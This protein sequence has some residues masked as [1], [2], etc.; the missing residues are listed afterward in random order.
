MV[1]DTETNSFHP[2]V[3]DNAFYETDCTQSNISIF[4]AGNASKLLIYSFYLSF[5]LIT[6]YIY[7]RHKGLSQ[8]NQYINDLSKME[9]SKFSFAQLQ[10][11]KF[12]KDKMFDSFLKIWFLLS[13]FI[14]P[15]YLCVIWLFYVIRFNDI[16]YINTFNPWIIPFIIIY[17]LYSII[18]I[19][20]YSFYCDF[21]RDKCA[22]L[23]IKS[24][25]LFAGCYGMFMFYVLIKNRENL[26]EWRIDGFYGSNLKHCFDFDIHKNPTLFLVLFILYCLVTHH[27]FVILRAITAKLC[28]NQ[29]ISKNND[30]F[31]RNKKSKRCKGEKGQSSFERRCVIDPR[32]GIRAPA[33]CSND[34]GMDI[35]DIDDN[36]ETESE[37]ESESQSVSNHDICYE[38]ENEN[39]SMRSKRIGMYN[40]YRINLTPEPSSNNNNYK[41]KASAPPEFN[42]VSSIDPSVMKMSSVDS[43]IDPPSQSPIARAASEFV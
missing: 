39:D 11:V 2:N 3:W 42:L 35:F 16:N 28:Y 31:N 23:M 14:F 34:D 9:G 15:W 6:G 32:G 18:V 13:T 40:G 43:S 19:A 24:S 1:S 38:N 17:S 36:P 5:V 20:S 21:K 4:G 12:I 25:I 37:S 26:N 7:G 29:Y 22:L 33:Y 8:H 27:I 41:R 30:V 10:N